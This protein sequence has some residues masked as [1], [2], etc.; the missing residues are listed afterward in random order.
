MTGI[1]RFHMQPSRFNRELSPSDFD[2]I[3]DYI[4][5]HTVLIVPNKA[6][7]LV[8]EVEFYLYSNSH[9]DIYTHQN[10]EQKDFWSLYFHKYANGTYKSGTFKGMDITLG[11]DNQHCGV[12]IRGVIDTDTD[13]NIDGPCKTVNHFLLHFEVNNLKEYSEKYGNPVTSL[14]DLTYCDISHGHK[15]IRGPRIGLSDKSSEYRDRLYRYGIS[16]LKYK[17]KFPPQ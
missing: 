12:L 3:A 14:V 10:I 13:L 15:L 9:P 1:Q 7:Y 6:S 17:H 11:N 2:D 4:I 5:N 16:G 8:R